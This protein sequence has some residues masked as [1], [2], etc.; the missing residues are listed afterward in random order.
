MLRIERV[1]S[2]AT[3]SDRRPS[4]VIRDVSEIEPLLLTYS[5]QGLTVRFCSLRQPV[6]AVIH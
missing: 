2:S 1:D 3:N 4:N 5:R 6:V